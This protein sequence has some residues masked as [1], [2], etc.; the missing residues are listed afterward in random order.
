MFIIEMLEA[1]VKVQIVSQYSVRN[2]ARLLGRSTPAGVQFRIS[3]DLGF[4]R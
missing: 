4:S 2:Y 3:E 1:E